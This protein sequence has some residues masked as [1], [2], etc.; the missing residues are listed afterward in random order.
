MP[1]ATPESVAQATA[2]SPSVTPRQSSPTDNADRFAEQKRE[3]EEQRLALER[4]SLAAEADRQRLEAEANLKQMRLAAEQKRELEN[5]S[6]ALERQRLEE[7]I[8]LSQMRLELERQKLEQERQAL[9]LKRQQQAVLDTTK[10]VIETRGS[11]ATIKKV[12]TITGAAR[13]DGRLARVEVAGRKVELDARTGRFATA[14]TVPLGQTEIRI[15]ATD[16][17]GNKA[18][19]IVSVTRKRAIPNI[20]FGD[21]H[22]V[23]IGIDDYKSLPKLKTAVV[24]A[25]AVAQTLKDKYDFKVHLLENPTRGDII[26]KFDEWRETLAEDDNLLIYYAGHGWQDPQTGRGYWL[27]VNARADR[28]SRWISNATLTDS[29]Q[30][31][32]AKHVMVVADSCYSGTLTRSIKVPERD[33]A[34]LERIAGKRTR[35][36]LSSG[37]LEPVADSG[38]GRHSVF[39]AQFL[40]ALRNNEGVLDG[41]QLFEKVRQ[42]V[43]LNATQT[44]EYSDIRFAGHEG[45]DFLFVRRE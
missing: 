13:D 26:D 15:T 25:Q 18:V 34:Y 21:Y 22:A 30:G 42:G 33:R 3:L 36:V 14:I 29:L 11:L 32:F 35:V 28:R 8:K 38:G 16:A 23:V 45:G 19:R 12:V 10:P 1:P 17:S 7:E 41:M 2:R 24:D 37:G 20:A 39:A 31:L 9:A 43:V 27:P 5:Q 44:P 6:M 4:Q 40:K